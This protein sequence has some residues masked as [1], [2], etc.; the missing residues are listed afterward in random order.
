MSEPPA[1]NG[2]NH[3]FITA[4]NPKA[5]SAPMRTAHPPFRTTIPAPI[6]THPT[7]TIWNGNHGPS[8]P[9]NIPDANVPTAPNTNPKPGPNALPATSTTVNIGEN[10]PTNPGRRSAT[11]AAPRTPMSATAFGPI[12]PR[13]SSRNR[14]VPTQ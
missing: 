3:R 2:Q 11:I 12:P 10:P 1:P 4:A 9:T 6:A 7:A 13:P 14:S 5:A 8:P